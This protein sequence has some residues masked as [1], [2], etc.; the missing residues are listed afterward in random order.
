[1]PTP[2]SRVSRVLVTLLGA[3]VVAALFGAFT[4]DDPPALPPQ[5]APA[6]AP[7]AAKARRVHLLINRKDEAGG[8]VV[9]EDEKQ[10]SIEREGK[11]RD[12]Q[13][14]DLLD[15]IQLLDVT[16]PTQAVVFRRDGSSIQ[17]SLLADDFD[18]VRYAVGR[19]QRTIPRAEVYRVGLVRT[20]E[21]RLRALK[22]SIHPDDMARRLALCDWLMSER[23]YTEARAELLP[24]VADSKL[25][26]AV[27]LLA[28][29]DAQLALMAAKKP[30]GGDASGKTPETESPPDA[31]PLPTR[32]L[33]A[34]EV[35]LIRVYEIDFD[36]PPRVII[37]PSDARALFEEFSASPRVPPDAAGRNAMLEGD[38]MQIVRLAFELK[39]RNFY[40]KIRVTSEPATL[41]KYRGAVH[42]G[43]L[44]ANC[45]T[46]RCHGGADAGKFFLSNGER[47][48]ERVRY[49]NLLNLLLGSSQDLP[50]VNFSDPNR[51]ILVQY[52]LPTDE[53]EIPHPAVKG[54]KPVFGRKLA[55][56]KL[57]A[58]LQWI[59]SMYQPR[60][61][62]P[63]DYQPPDLRA[64]QPGTPGDS[65]EPTR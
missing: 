8:V 13:K 43:W 7:E 18:A 56:E 48:D 31:R 42:D 3:M 49:T 32:L 47:S 40:P 54:W 27:A 38:P 4:A 20:F 60:P 21:E 59:A 63:I 52:A 9:Y 14:D 58:T 45:A 35:N 41:V 29:A 30:Q 11:R 17:V 34:A 37:E 50:L 33:T 53:A 36:N 55:P 22:E 39:A 51:S 10:I 64:P 6:A 23:K 57:R 44:L 24:L 61:I 2:S 62:Y 16:I 65:Q 26:E 12:F 15:I 5:G 1:M 19:S 28:R 46:S 25:P